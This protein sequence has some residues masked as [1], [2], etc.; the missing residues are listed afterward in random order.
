MSPYGR[1]YISLDSSLCQIKDCDGSSLTTLKIE[2]QFQKLM[3]A[4]EL[5]R[6]Y[7]AGQRYFP[8]AQLNGVKLIAAYLP[9]INLWG[10]DLSRA[11]LAQAKLWGA[12][13]SQANL[14]QAN[15][16][17]ANLSGVKLK[18]AN[19][20]GAKLNLVKCYGADF[21]GAC[22]DDSTRFSRGFDPQSQNMRK[23]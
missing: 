4:Q 8:A 11:N 17:R 5:I 21:T 1:F 19:L 20:R 7:N 13:L 2:I 3:D 6:R 14:A 16:T 23:F 22:Y 12:D 10:A 9:G 18:E 15:L